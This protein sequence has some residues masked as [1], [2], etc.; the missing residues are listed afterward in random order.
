MSGNNNMNNKY[1]ARRGTM[2]AG[3]QN[4][5]DGGDAPGQ[6]GEEEKSSYYLS[7]SAERHIRRQNT[8]LIE[9]YDDELGL[10][11]P[12]ASNHFVLRSEERQ[13]PLIMLN[14]D[15]LRRKE[16]RVSITIEETFLCE[17]AENYRE[18][19]LYKIADCCKILSMSST[20]IGST[21]HPQAEYCY[22]DERDRMTYVL[23][24]FLTYN[25]LAL[26]VQY[27]AGTR[28]QGTQ[29]SA[30]NEVIR[31]IRFSPP[32]P[33]DSY[34]LVSEPRL[35]LGYR[36]P[37]DFA[38]TDSIPLDDVGRT[39][40]DRADDAL[41]YSRS[42]AVSSSTSSLSVPFITLVGRGARHMGVISSYEPSVS[43]V[44][45]GGPGVSRYGW[46]QYL[47]MLVLT[48]VRR[49]GV[50][51]CVPLQL[52][53]KEDMQ[54]R[55]ETAGTILIRPYQVNVSCKG[56]FSSDEG[57]EKG[58][59]KL[60][61][62]FCL[63]YENLDPNSPCLPFLK[64]TDGESGRRAY[65]SIFVF[66][67]RDECVSFCFIASATRH[68]VEEFF[69]F[70]TT[71][72]E[73]ISLGNH[74]G[75]STS[76]LYCNLRHPVAPFIMSL[77]AQDAV[78]VEEPLLGDPLAVFH[79]HGLERITVTLRVFPLTGRG[80]QQSGTTTPAG[81]PTRGSR[82]YAKMLDHLLRHHLSQLPGGCHRPRVGAVHG[83][84]D[85]SPQT[86]F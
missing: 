54:G 31:S 82:Y 14:L 56:N 8:N 36:V 70:C 53:F 21:Q 44:V 13:A 5:N 34:L 68:S 2:V 19:S 50:Q 6:R 30:F 9:W 40:S 24:V 69:S 76:M 32:R 16:H 75:Q 63:I 29:P 62:S 65:V 4:Y 46:Q 60:T 83:A 23:A 78:T 25:R 57:D 79:Y 22:L 27:V 33:S 66:P 42:N 80:E 85:D 47:E 59:V 12:F 86:V 11:I 37:L 52:L 26:T 55:Q 45:G 3:E 1:G 48:T 73:S 15:C 20:R 51:P 7:A 28:I 64:P 41:Y 84:W 38:S 81:R 71:T 43:S 72:I 67:V 74:H 58:C 77:G 61:G 17:T 35:G 10:V 18:S 49:L 39:A